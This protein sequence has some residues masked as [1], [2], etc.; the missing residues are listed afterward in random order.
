MKPNYLPLGTTIPNST[1]RRPQPRCS[2]LLPT[3]RRPSQPATAAAGAT[4]LATTRAPPPA[5][6]R[7]V[8]TAS[9]RGAV[10]ANRD[11]R[12]RSG[13]STRTEG[14]IP[15]WCRRQGLGL[16]LWAAATACRRLRRLSSSTESPSPSAAGRRR[17]LSRW[18]NWPI[19]YK[20]LMLIQ[21]IVKLFCF[22]VQLQQP[23]QRPCFVLQHPPCPSQKAVSIVG[24]R[25]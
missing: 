4:T 18:S 6:S 10:R 7:A 15:T 14:R 12:R 3:R 22:I 11:A 8:V 25:K 1:K 21:N 23:R 5:G 20:R 24:V 2:S 9:R 17:R 13:C 16:G 19:Q